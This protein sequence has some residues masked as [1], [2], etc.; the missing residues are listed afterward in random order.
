MII[1]LVEQLLASGATF[2]TSL[3]ALRTLDTDSLSVFFLLISGLQIAVVV[4]GARRI[5]IYVRSPTSLSCTFLV[6]HRAIIEVIAAS[7]VVTLVAVLL[8]HR[9]FD[10]L[11]LNWV[12]LLELLAFSVSQLLA[13]WLRRT[14]SVMFVHRLHLALTAAQFFRLSGPFLLITLPVSSVHD[15]SIFFGVLSVSSLLAVASYLYSFR[16]SRESMLIT[17]PSDRINE[18][19]AKINKRVLLETYQILAWANI[20]ITV[21]AIISGSPG[22][23]RLVEVRTPLSFFNPVIEF[24]EVHIRGLTVDRLHHSRI[25]LKIATLIGLWL[26]VS[27]LILWFGD[28]ASSLIAGRP[29][30]GIAKDLIIFWWL[31]FLL[32]VDRLTHNL[33]RKEVHRNAFIS[34]VIA[35]GLALLTLTIMLIYQFSVT[36]CIVAMCIWCSANI[37][38]RF[39]FH[40]RKG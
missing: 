10:A 32:I 28:Q 13:E 21:L 4:L 22:V 24:I 38:L 23:A 5:S 8:L 9:N 39:F 29:I 6:G 36:G 26:I 31:Q 19:M 37:L 40:Q 20:P 33:E 2:V 18:T 16:I 17:Q 25:W 30:S 12:V 14:S 15:P 1:R 3:V 7:A 35:I 27:G 11:H 34:P